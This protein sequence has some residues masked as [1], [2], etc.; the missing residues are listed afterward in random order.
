M[1]VGLFLVCVVL[2]VVLAAPLIALVRASRA[3]RLARQSDERLAQL[4]ARIW[5]LEQQ[6]IGLTRQ[7]AKPEG[8]EEPVRQTVAS[9]PP[10]ETRAPE[11]LPPAPAV[12]ASEP[13]TA[14]SPPPAPA[15]SEP[16]L[17]R[18]MFAQTLTHTE[19]SKPVLSA[20][21]VLGTNWL[22]KLGIIILVIGVS[23]FLAY[24]LKTLGPSGKI[25]VGYMVGGVLLGAGIL[26]EKREHYRILARAGIGGGWA[27]LYFTT[28]A[29]HH[30]EAACIIA[31]QAVDLF[32]LLVVAAAMVTHTLGIARRQ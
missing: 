5:A 29:M 4:T 19:P 20:E 7:A 14:P 10:A 22:N 8:P 9:I 12:A 21:E 1:V 32:L 17:M 6:I 13:A 26:L 31:S 16:A 27:L 24:Q 2:G 3:A 28:Y 30:V 15:A 25:L 11:T 23:L 18:P